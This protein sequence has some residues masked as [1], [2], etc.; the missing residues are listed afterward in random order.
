MPAHTW[1]TIP[2]LAPGHF[3]RLGLAAAAA[4]ACVAE[5]ICP[6][7]ALLVLDLLLLLQQG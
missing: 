3:L 5:G 4:G 2:V 7:P 1:Q 6:D